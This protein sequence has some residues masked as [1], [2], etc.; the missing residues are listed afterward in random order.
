MHKRT[1]SVV[2]MSASIALILAAGAG[3]AYATTFAPGTQRAYVQRVKETL[4]A[5]AAAYA[6]ANGERFTPIPGRRLASF[7]DPREGNPADRAYQV[8]WSYAS[9]LLEMEPSDATLFHIDP[10]LRYG[11]TL[12]PLDPENGDFDNFQNSLFDR[13]NGLPRP[14][15]W[16]GDGGQIAWQTIILDAINRWD[17]VCSVEFHFL[18]GNNGD[19]NA[20]ADQPN[21]DGG[22]RWDINAPGFNDSGFAEGD[23]RIAMCELDGPTQPDGSGGGILAWTYDPVLPPAGDTLDDNDTPDDFSDDV[24]TL[25]YLGNILLDK[26]ERWN[27]PATP[28]LLAT[29]ITREIGFALGAVPA[30]PSDPD[31]PIALLQHQDI[32]PPG[33]P[34][35]QDPL[36]QLFFQELQEDDIRSIHSVFGDSLDTWGS[37]QNTTTYTD[38]KDVFFFPIPGT[39]T[40]S[41]IPHLGIPEVN[42]EGEPEFPDGPLS[43]SIHS[44]TDIDRWRLSIPDSV[45]SGTLS[46]TVEPRGTPYINDTFILPTPGESVINGSCNGTPFEE[47]A[48]AVRNLRI[49]IE[50]YDPFTN[51]LQLID[52][53]DLTPAGESETVEIPVT[54]GTYYISVLADNVNNVQLYDLTMIVDT[55]LIEAGMEAEEYLEAVDVEAFRE[56]GFFGA[57]ANIGIIDGEHLAD[58][59]D[60]F[61]GRTVPRVSWPG[62]QPAATTAG[63][64]ATIVAGVASGAPIGGFEGLAPEASLASASVASTVFGDGT[65]TVGKNALYFALMSLADATTAST[66]GLPAPASVIIAT[67]GAGGRTLNGEDTISQAFDIVASQSQSTF[68][69]AAGNAGQTEGQSFANCIIQ[70]P[71]PGGPGS[72]YL[73]YRTIVPPGT[74]FNGIVVGGVG[75]VDPVESPAEFAEQSFVVAG[76]SSRGPVDSSLNIN[77]GQDLI[78][79]R[80]GIDVIAPATGNTIIPQDFDPT[81]GV[82]VDPCTYDGPRATTLLLLPSI[83]PGDDPDAPAN[84]G[85]FQLAQGTSVAAAI[86]GGGVAL[87]QDVGLSQDPPLSIHP[88]VMKAIIMNGAEKLEG[89]TNRPLG[90]GVP[91]DQRDGFDRN[92]QLQFD[93]N[94]P[95]VYN[96]VFN[97]NTPLDRAQGAGV[98]NLRRS[99]ENYF[100]GYAPAAPP[101]T[102]FDGPTIDPPETDPRVP[103]IRIPDEPMGTGGPGP[104]GNRPEGLVSDSDGEGTDP[105]LPTALSVVRPMSDSEIENMRFEQ[106]GRQP[107]PDVLM[108][109][110]M[111]AGPG[112]RG[113]DLKNFNSN[114]PG[115][116]VTTGPQTPFTIPSLGDDDPDTGPPTNNGTPGTVELGFRP[117]EI[118]PIFVDPMG[119]DLANIDQRPIR[120]FTGGTLQDGFI[121]YVINVP[122]LAERPDPS[123]PGGAV[124]PADQLTVTLT[125]QRTFTLTQINFSN[126]SAPIIGSLRSQELENLDLELF[127]CDSLG[128]VSNGTVAVR[129]SISTFNTTEHIF[130]GIPLS[131]LYLIRVRWRNTEY[132]VRTNLPLAEQ[133]YGVAWRVDFSPRAE[134][135]RPTGAS[136]L[137]N[138]LNNFGGQVGNERYTIDSDVDLNGKVNWSD[139]MSVLR[140]WSSN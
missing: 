3:S 73:G 80:S 138:V 13:F 14:F 94:A 31:V 79:R 22:G 133:V 101:Q 1:Q 84:P 72:D 89:W 19:Q 21:G 93:A 20:V 2:R 112:G 134:A 39:S 36:P 10:F 102:Q 56:E 65:F 25:G 48:S 136:D 77:G 60:V 103:T 118:P 34:G 106:R 35:Q 26:E 108:A 128:N 82:P 18:P 42:I 113:P 97:T 137:V 54:T 9:P 119:W 38:A 46:V 11:Q 105:E 12:D 115:G 58:L 53:V 44:N 69:I 4:Q 86:V 70:T 32:L 111:Q 62:I 23:I 117:R 123:N 140:N 66:V 127:P 43:L 96:L 121:D 114:N 24:P 75:F 100:T 76:L 109:R 64:H 45:T 68:V 47:D 57:N 5:K 85:S 30:C 98:V 95:L 139:V 126:P 88:M 41:Y 91:Q 61:A 135:L 7:L 74:A 99:L 71:D 15:G 92:P 52:D 104:P 83:D 55:P 122:L 125:W 129:S 124:L 120:Q 27:D 16:Q 78:D 131:S 90:P 33:A 40:F 116:L 49:R 87:L 132:D 107:E 81:G 37:G 63:T 28:N 67:F 59:H 6:A 50:A 110:P 17:Q 130:T 51:V 29:V 8:W